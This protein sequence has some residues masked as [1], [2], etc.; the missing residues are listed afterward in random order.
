MEYFVVDMP[1]IG[2]RIKQARLKR[3]LKVSDLRGRLGLESDQ[4]IYK[5]QRGEC[6]PAI[7]N[8]YVL[9]KML[10]VTMEYLVSGEGE[11]SE[12][13]SSFNIHFIGKLLKMW[14]NSALVN[15]FEKG[16]VYTL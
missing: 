2:E 3:H 15:G 16:K 1:A 9:S 14:Y 13:D 8:L 12:R 11:E 6:L 10:G 5:W 4:A 7:E